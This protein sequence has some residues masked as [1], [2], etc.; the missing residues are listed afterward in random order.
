[1][2]HRRYIKNVDLKAAVMDF[3]HSHVDAFQYEYEKH[4]RYARYFGKYCIAG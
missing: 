4:V 2:K 3:I 1:M